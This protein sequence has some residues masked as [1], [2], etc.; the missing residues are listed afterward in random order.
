M[1]L[2]SGSFKFKNY[3]KQ[4]VVLFNIYADFECNVKGVRSS[5]RNNNTSYTEK[6]QAHIPCSFVYKVVC[7]DEKFSKSFVLYRGKMGSINSLKQF[8]K[9]MISATK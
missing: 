2:R 1:K 7:V 6:Y 9:I 8:L 4:L 3:C 5:D